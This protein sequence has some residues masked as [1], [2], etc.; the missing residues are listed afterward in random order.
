[1]V[2]SFDRTP[3]ITFNVIL[4]FPILAVILVHLIFASFSLFPFTR[5]VLVIL[6]FSVSPILDKYPLCTLLFFSSNIE[7]GFPSLVLVVS[8][9]S[10]SSHRHLVF[11]HTSGFR[12]VGVH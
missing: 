10:E 12:I 4:T 2:S 5:L 1:M 3:V 11:A 7:L 9:P 8:S 6:P